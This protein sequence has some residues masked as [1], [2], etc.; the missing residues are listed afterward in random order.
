MS[1]SQKTLSFWQELL[2]GLPLDHEIT[3]ADADFFAL[4]RQN[5]KIVNARHLLG[6]TIM[7]LAIMGLFG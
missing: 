1:Q 5:S 6:G 3:T 2:T 7:I 4:D